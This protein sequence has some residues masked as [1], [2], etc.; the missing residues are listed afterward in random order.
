MLW[1][2]PQFIVMTMGE[3]MF[4]ITGLEFSFTQA[5]VS[6]KSILQALWCLTVAFGDLIV[7]IVAESRFFKSQVIDGFF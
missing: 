6:M 1:L 3:I 7:V 4:S 5:S 2:L